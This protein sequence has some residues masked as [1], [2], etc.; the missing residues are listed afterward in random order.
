MLV[1]DKAA[2]LLTAS[3]TMDLFTGQSIR[4]KVMN[5][6]ESTAELKDSLIGIPETIN[7]M[8][9]GHCISRGKYIKVNERLLPC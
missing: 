9:S 3:V 1:K 8:T 7:L 4:K 6:I 2:A 5:R